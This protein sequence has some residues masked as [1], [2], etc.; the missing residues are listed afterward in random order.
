MTGGR[1]AGR[2]AA[3]EIAGRVARAVFI[4]YIY[5]IINIYIYMYVFGN[6]STFISIPQEKRVHRIAG[7]MSSISGMSHDG[8]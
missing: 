5:I 4:I 8:D 3:G 7:L 6:V 1:P 2:P